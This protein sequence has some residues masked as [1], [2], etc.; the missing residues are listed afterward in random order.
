ML[1]AYSDSPLGVD[2]SPQGYLI[3]FEGLIFIIMYTF[4]QDHPNKGKDGASCDIWALR[5]G[6]KLLAKTRPKTAAN[7]QTSADFQTVLMNLLL[8]PS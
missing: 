1:V 8:G 6:R 5:I 2:V 7:P 3:V 4:A